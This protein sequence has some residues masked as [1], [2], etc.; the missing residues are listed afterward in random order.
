[1][2]WKYQIPLNFYPFA[3]Y[4]T[5]NILLSSK[6]AV[7]VAISQKAFVRISWYIPHLKG[8]CMPVQMQLMA[9]LETKFTPSCLLCAASNKASEGKNNNINIAL[10]IHIWLTSGI[11]AA[12]GWEKPR[13]IGCWWVMA[14]LRNLGF[15]LREFCVIILSHWPA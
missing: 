14:T 6:T 7:R 8:F 1:M 3:R 5:K 10:I 15:Q 4:I 13:G 2:K 9:C 11:E 12:Q